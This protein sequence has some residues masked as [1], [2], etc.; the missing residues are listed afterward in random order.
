VSATRF[1]QPAGRAVLVNRRVVRREV[2]LEHPALHVELATER[3]GKG[4]EHT[5]VWGTGPDL[6]F[7]VPLWKD[8]TVTLNRQRRFGIK[9]PSIE[10]PGGHVEED[11]TPEEGVRREL[12][13]ETGL[14][15]KTVTHVLTCL[16][17]AKIQQNVHVYLAEG[18]SRGR[19][20]L[21]AD[22]EIDLVR[23]HFETALRRGLSGWILHMPS[24]VALLAVGEHLRTRGVSGRAS[25]SGKRARGRAS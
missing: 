8:G 23:V 6:A 7:A 12:R 17:S 5:Y 14:A 10:V 9:R 2:A 19:R 15:A 1:V 24:L 25:A 16:L 13:E 4:R 21:D 18:L 22:E 20:Q 11:E 3:D